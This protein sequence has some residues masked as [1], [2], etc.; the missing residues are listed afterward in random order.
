MG[1][2]LNMDTQYFMCFGK[3]FLKQLFAVGS[4]LSLPGRAE[5][6]KLGRAVCW[7]EVVT[8]V[9]VVALSAA[10]SKV[11]VFVRLDDTNE[12][13]AYVAAAS[14]GSVAACTHLPTVCTVIEYLS[15]PFVASILRSRRRCHLRPLDW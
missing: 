15:V 4:K 1:S 10:T 11:L 8:L 13:G 12:P 5:L 7:W 2:W 6:R 14:S 9:C 3:N